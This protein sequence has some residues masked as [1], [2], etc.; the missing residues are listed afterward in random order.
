MSAAVDHLVY[1]SHA[2]ANLNYYVTRLSSYYSDDQRAL[3]LL[4]LDILARQPTC[5]A[6]LELLNLCKHRDP[7][8]TDEQVRGVLTILA[9][10]HYVERTRCP[11]GLAYDFRWP[12]VKKW[13]RETRP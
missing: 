2:P 6:V 10:D 12:L 7:A 13:R 5:T 8:V 9:E 3:A 1:D 4:V 11:T